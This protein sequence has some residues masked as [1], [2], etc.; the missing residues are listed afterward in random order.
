[1]SIGCFSLYHCKLNTFELLKT[2]PWTM[3][4]SVLVFGSVDSDNSKFHLLTSPNPYISS[5]VWPLNWRVP[6]LLFFQYF[7]SQEFKIVSSTRTGSKLHPSS[8]GN[9]PSW[10]VQCLVSGRGCTE[11]ARRWIGMSGLILS[12]TALVYTI[13]S[14]SHFCCCCCFLW[15]KT[16][17]FLWV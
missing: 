16:L 15:W 12:A 2:L 1:M 10:P 14:C 13:S 17:L 6:S 11:K 4:M 9:R 5:L 3:E 8:L 7:S